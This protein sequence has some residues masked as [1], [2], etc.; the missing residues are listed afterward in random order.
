MLNTSNTS[1]SSNMVDLTDEIYNESDVP[2]HYIS[3]LADLV[4]RA[5]NFAKTKTIDQRLQVASVSDDVI[6]IDDPEE[7][8]DNDIETQTKQ[9]PQVK[10]IFNTI[11]VLFVID[12]YFSYI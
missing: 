8:N 6:V 11:F 1:S 3:W 10:N 9:K 2:R 12:S 4:E 7:V 5:N